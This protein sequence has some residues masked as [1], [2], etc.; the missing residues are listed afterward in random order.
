MEYR[1]DTFPSPP[2]AYSPVTAAVHGSTFQLGSGVVLD[3]GRVL[4]VWCEKT[5]ASTDFNWIQLGYADSVL[6]Y[7]TSDGSV[8]W[9]RT[10]RYDDSTGVSNGGSGYRLGEALAT[11]LR[12]PDGSIYIV[13]WAGGSN[14]VN[15]VWDP[16]VT[17]PAAAG[18]YNGVL[19]STDEG[20]TWDFYA[21]VPASSTP[22]TNKINLGGVRGNWR[23]EE[24]PAE[25]QNA[26]RWL[27]AGPG[28]GGYASGV[29]GQTQRGQIWSS[30]DQGATWTLRTSGDNS[31]VRGSVYGAGFAFAHDGYIYTKRDED[32][33]GGGNARWYRSTDGGTTWTLIQTYNYPGSPDWD[34]VQVGPW[35]TRFGDTT[36]IWT[37]QTD[38]SDGSTGPNVV[39]WAANVYDASPI[40]FDTDYTAET[41]WAIANRSFANDEI[42]LTPLDANWAGMWIGTQVIGLPLV[43]CPATDLLHIP[44]KAWVVRADAR[45]RGVWRDENWLTI[46]RWARRVTELGATTEDLHVPAIEEDPRF[47]YDAWLSVERWSRTVCWGRDLHIP[48]KER[49]DMDFWNCL[50]MERWANRV[51]GV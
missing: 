31:T 40:Q 34:Y 15:T 36:R 4:H 8:T 2:I 9:D 25:K 39:G 47:I 7:L 38:N 42:L 12:A 50:A 24:I 49:V 23:I 17:T 48:Y 27:M 6:D 43:S 11:V 10:I 29:G 51:D 46:K 35:L 14:D 3:D 44:H 45:G 20:D 33:S 5:Q 26:G 16:S 1:F 28:H 18:V 37:F 32:D 22:K 21:D 41:T 30:D 19:R 13:W